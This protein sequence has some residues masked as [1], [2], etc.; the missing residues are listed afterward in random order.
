MLSAIILAAAVSVA[1][2]VHQIQIEHQNSPMA[3][4]YR[5]DT[6]VTTRQIGMAAGTR[7]STERCVWTAQVRVLREATRPNGASW[8]HR[9]DADKTMS[10][11]QPGKC[12]QNQKRIAG[13]M[14]RRGDDIRAHLAAVAA[15]DK[16]QLAADLHASGEF[17]AS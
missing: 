4:S 5:A 7:T 12:S 13:E 11:S 16:A 9:L 8:Q 15:S 3:V 1:D 10:G 6:K 2:H 14:A 17:S